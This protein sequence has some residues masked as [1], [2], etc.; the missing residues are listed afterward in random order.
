MNPSNQT[1]KQIIK[2]VALSFVLLNA[3]GAA[4]SNASVQTIQN[5]FKWFNGISS[6]ER[7]SFTE[8]DVARYFHPEAK[9]LTNNVLVCEGIKEHFEHFNE[10]NAHYHSLSVSLDHIKFY[11]VDDKVFLDYNLYGKRND[12]SEVT[13]TVMGYMQIKDGKIVLFKEVI[14]EV[15]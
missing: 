2:A 8:E 10:L 4:A 14:H 5:T 7:V 15:S 9:M 11:P 12:G 13:I 6:I 1:L 3:K